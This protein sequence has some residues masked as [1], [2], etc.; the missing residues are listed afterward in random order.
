MRRTLDRLAATSR[1]VLRMARHRGRA[2][3]RY[4]ESDAAF[5]ER[6]FLELLG[7]PVD[8]PGRVHYLHALER[9]VAREQVLAALRQSDEH[10]ALERART[11]AQ[12]LPNLRARHPDRYAVERTTD[13]RAVDVYI[14]GDPGEFDWI[15]DQIGRCRYY[16][17]PG[18][19]N[20]GVDL[21]K[22]VMAELI[23]RLDPVR[24][25]EVGCSSGSVLEC[26]V[27]RGVDAHG[28]EISEYAK[29]H[30]S[31][32]VRDRI[33]IGDVRT[34]VLDRGFDV[35]F[36]LDIFEHIN[37]N[38]LDEFI[39]AFCALLESR[40]FV[41]ANIP[42]FGEDPVFGEV[43]DPFLPSWR[44]DAAAGR[45]FRNLQVDGRGFPMHGHLVWA[46]SAWWVERFEAHGLRREPEVEAALHDQYDWYL[47]KASPAR[48]SFYVFSIGVDEN[49][50][51]Q[52]LS[53]CRA[54]GAS[55]LD[56]VR[57]DWVETGL[58][59]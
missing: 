45:I 5:V 38:M 50:R 48:L 17:I 36:G 3:Q 43:F 19:W 14:A 41:F 34:L 42:A 26:L 35:G 32:K 7:R 16:E 46:S 21:D 8:G 6:A 11:S 15:D 37:P 44:R 13:G 30:A 51:A 56:G 53:R 49:E 52:T 47:E 23:A 20:L 2:P 18:I 27:A 57:A 31:S 59:I 25:L 1:D 39:G 54:S 58:L 10:A 9:G 12:A 29:H 33:H 28:V 55:V 40:A 4:E 22:E 24:A